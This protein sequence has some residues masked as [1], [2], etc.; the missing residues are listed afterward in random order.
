MLGDGSIVWCKK[1][2]GANNETTTLGRKM[3]N[4]R[5]DRLVYKSRQIK[6]MAITPRSHPEGPFSDGLEGVV[7]PRG[8][9]VD[10]GA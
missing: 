7:W 2:L 4:A 8:E 10:G 3:P 9:P 5:G 6:A 1:R